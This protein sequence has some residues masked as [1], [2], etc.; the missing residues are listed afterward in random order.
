[1][2]E[3]EICFTAS[4]PQAQTVPLLKSGALLSKRKKPLTMSVRG[5]GTRYHPDLSRRSPGGLSAAHRV[6]ADNGA[7]R[8]PLRADG[9]MKEETPGPVIHGGPPPARSSRRL[10][11]GAGL[12]PSPSS[13]QAFYLITSFFN[14]LPAGI[15]IQLNDT[16]YPIISYGILLIFFRIPSKYVRV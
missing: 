13:L 4:T 5:V 6:S 12:R 14:R 2:F 15:R 10:S 1:M 9:H 3:K 16:F 11:E 7:C 8:P